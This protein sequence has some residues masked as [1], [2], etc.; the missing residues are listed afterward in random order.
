[1]AAQKSG[2][3]AVPPSPW[4]RALRAAR[5]AAPRTAARRRNPARV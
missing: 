4:P 2:G 1:M 3:R 5:R